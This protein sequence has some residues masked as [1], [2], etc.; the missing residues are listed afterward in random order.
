MRP[1]AVFL[2]LAALPV[3]TAA[4]GGIA[5]RDVGAGPEGVIGPGGAVRF[6]ALPLD[7]RTVVTKT[8]LQRGLVKRA[9]V[10]PGR[11]SVPVVA[12][13]YTAGGLSADGSTL[14]LGPA[15]SR[16]TARRSSFAVLDARSLTVRRTIALEGWWHFDALS[17]DA[18]TLYLSQ[19]VSARTGRYAVRAYDLR[20]G[21]LLRDPIVDPA[22]PDEPM[23]GYP[24][25]RVTGP[26]G[27]WVYTLYAGGDHPFVHALDTVGRT[28]LCLDLPKRVERH[29]WRTKLRLNGDRVEAVYRDRVVASAA[30]RPQQASTGGGPP[31]AALAGVSGLVAAAVGLRRVRRTG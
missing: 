13:D 18:S 30:R 15:P 7:D 14:V 24:M 31:W 23:R 29:A 11:L 25:T 26:G 2:V 5:P 8:A 22:E 6:G 10:L 19:T 12:Q 1:L 9:A 20:R 27:R 3:S 4:A 21:R 16:F 17:P 28:S